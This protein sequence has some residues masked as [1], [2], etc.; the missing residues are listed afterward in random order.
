MHTMW[1]WQDIESHRICD[2]Q[3]VRHPLTL[4]Q[5][6]TAALFRCHAQ[7]AVANSAKS[8]AEMF[9]WLATWSSTKASASLSVLWN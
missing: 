3:I 2:V 4:R 6:M 7:S 8:V 5:Q 1:A 9:R